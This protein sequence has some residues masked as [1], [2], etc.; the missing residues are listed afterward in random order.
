M[1]APIVTGATP[2]WI[3][4]VTLLLSLCG[5]SLVASFGELSP[6][7]KRLVG[8]ALAAGLAAY[9]IIDFA[10]YCSSPVWWMD[11]YCW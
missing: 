7:L 1:T 10:V 9:V 8:G 4:T 6:R 2:T 11:I 5:I 3:Y